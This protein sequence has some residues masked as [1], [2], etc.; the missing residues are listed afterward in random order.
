MT[1]INT[2]TME[3]NPNMI[4]GDTNREIEDKGDKIIHYITTQA[5]VIKALKLQIKELNLEVKELDHD[6][7]RLKHENEETKEELEFHIN[8]YSDYDVQCCY[9]GCSESHKNTEWTYITGDTEDNYAIYDSLWT[10]NE[11]SIKQ[12]NEDSDEEDGSG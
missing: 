10:C 11:C 3:E 7:K 1:I 12:E 9:C 2:E 8:R 4:Y 6:N 5:N